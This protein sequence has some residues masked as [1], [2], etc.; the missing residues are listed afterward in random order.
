MSISKNE[1]VVEVMGTEPNPPRPPLSPVYNFKPMADN[2]W[3]SLEA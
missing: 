3:I 1:G 2:F